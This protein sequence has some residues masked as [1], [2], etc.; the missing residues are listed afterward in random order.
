MMTLPVSISKS[1]FALIIRSPLLPLPLP[2]A[3]G[4]F[5]IDNDKERWSGSSEKYPRDWVV[6]HEE[7]MKIIHCH[8]LAPFACFLAGASL[9]QE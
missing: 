2:V 1:L 7:N 5:T 6:K 4:L 8:R 3:L 9:A